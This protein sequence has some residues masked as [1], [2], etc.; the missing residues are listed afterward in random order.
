MKQ[1]VVGLRGFFD[2]FFKLPLELWAGFLAGWPGLPNNEK[3]E[4][5]NARIWFGINFL[6]RLPPQVA[7]DMVA[8]IVQYSLATGAPLVQSVTPFL[9]APP[10]YEY[11][12]FGME[13]VGD[14]RA[15]AEAKRLILESKVTELLPPA[16]VDGVEV[17]STPPATEVS[18]EDKPEFTAEEFIPQ[19]DATSH[20]V[21]VE[22]EPASE[23]ET[24]SATSEITVEDVPEVVDEEPVGEG[25]IAQEA[26]T[27]ALEQV[28]LEVALEGEAVSQASE[29]AIEDKPEPVEEESVAEAV[30]EQEA[31]ET[32]EHFEEA[33]LVE[34]VVPL[35]SAWPLNSESNH[36]QM[37]SA[38]GDVEESIAPA[39]V[40]SSQDFS[41]NIFE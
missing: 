7:L 19:D 27:E 9:G 21:Q 36:E 25:V 35:E 22:W 18:G 33:E 4:S 15:K 38:A 34:E 6:A 10:S 29:T 2:G 3:H 30:M 5:W 17:E 39:P 31:T 1:N 16:F 32:A 28:E 23:E 8:S 41:Q 12:D 20:V 24:V 40:S 11:R 37:A 26:A 13:T 14:Q